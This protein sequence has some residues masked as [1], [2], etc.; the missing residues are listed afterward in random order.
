MWSFGCILAELVTGRPLFPAIDERELLEFFIIRIG[1][2]PEYMIN[3]CTKRR[4]F[5]DQNLNLIRSSR[6]RIPKGSKPKCDS[7]RQA[8]YSEDDDEFMYM[9]VQWL[10]RVDFMYSF[11]TLFHKS[12]FTI[13]SFTWTVPICDKV[14]HFIQYIFKHT[15]LHI[16][17]I[18]VFTSNLSELNI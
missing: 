17:H 16:T 6:S 5:Y 4:T 7:V 11:V 2:I 13:N 9:Y 10:N 3:K 14:I 8:L 1:Q 12:T 18:P 15:N